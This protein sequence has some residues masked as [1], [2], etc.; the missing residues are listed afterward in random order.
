VQCKKLAKAV[1]KLAGMLENL[2]KTVGTNGAFPKDELESCKLEIGQSQEMLQ[3]AQKAHD[4]AIDK[5]YELL[6]N[7]LSDDAQSQ[8][9]HV[10]RKMHKHDLWA[11]VN[12]QVTKGRHP[13][14]WT[15]FQHCLELHK[16]T[17]FTADVAKRQ[18]FYIQQAVH[19]PQR[20]TVR[21]CIL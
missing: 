17:V 1:D 20:A 7:L 8:C 18:Q 13:R 14:T 16:P 21:Q 5:R 15:A 19:K 9:D 10:C 2:Q 3:T 11:G 6:R 4:K 12:G